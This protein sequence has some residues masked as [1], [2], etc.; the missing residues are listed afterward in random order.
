MKSKRNF[1]L[2]ILTFLLLLMVFNG[3]ISWLTRTDKLVNTF[4]IGSFELP[5]TSPIDSSSVSLNG[6]L[7][8]P[9]WDENESHKLLP[10]LQYNKDP[11]VGI[12][13]GSEDAVVYVYVE[14][15]FTNKVYFNLNSGW[16]M[17][18]SSNGFASGTYTSGLFKY[19]EGLNNA[20][21][22]DVWTSTPLFNEIIIDET[23]VAS[24]FEVLNGKNTEIIVWSFIH[25]ASDGDGNKI[26][27]ATILEAAKKAFGM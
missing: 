4:T 27:D 10:G 13:K 24:D 14:N 17:V 2:I 26:D 16:E 22:S 23:A 8:E 11:Y 21:N 12:G 18:E 9:S 25:Q 1:I 6:H 15:N 20:I 7:Y 3:T 5:S 19:T